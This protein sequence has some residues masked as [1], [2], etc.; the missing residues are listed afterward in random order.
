M[1][2]LK[3]SRGLYPS[4]LDETRSVHSSTAA[5]RTSTNSPH[6][7][8]ELGTVGGPRLGRTMGH[9]KYE[10]RAVSGWWAGQQEVVYLI[11]C[12]N[13]IPIELVLLLQNSV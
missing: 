9:H 6:N 12:C 8:E 4:M 11:W 7:F 10:V 5:S 3:Q 13:F 2:N 1:L